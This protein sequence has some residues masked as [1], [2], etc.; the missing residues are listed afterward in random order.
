[1]ESDSGAA[2]KHNFPIFVRLKERVGNIWTKIGKLHAVLT[3]PEV[4][5]E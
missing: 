2:E 4:Y 1:M 5:L 3:F